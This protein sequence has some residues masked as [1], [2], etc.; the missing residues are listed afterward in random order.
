MTPTTSRDKKRKADD[1]EQRA[2]GG[3]SKTRSAPRRPGIEAVVPSSGAALRVVA[4]CVEG[5]RRVQRL[6]RW[7]ELQQSNAGATIR[8]A[9]CGNSLTYYNDLPHLVQSVLRHHYSSC[10]GGEVNVVVGA[11]LRGGQSLE[12]LFNRGADSGTAPGR[13]GAEI[14]NRN[15]FPTVLALLAAPSGWDYVVFQDHTQGPARDD[16]QPL[17]V[18]SCTPPEV[19]RGRSLGALKSLYLPL[20]LGMAKRPTMVVY[21]TYGYCQPNKRS[22]EVGDYQTMTA[23]L[24]AGYR[25]YGEELRAAGLTTLQVHVGRSRG[26]MAG[27][28]SCGEGCIRTTFSTRRR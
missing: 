8:V 25:L 15:M 14:G 21:E 9:F 16:S 22:E 12:S 4:A 5:V 3:E 28:K 20:L 17:H 26:Y 23:K 19:S 18:G 11:C 1:N 7:Q 13:A 10:G 2:P 27:R 24:A 6:S